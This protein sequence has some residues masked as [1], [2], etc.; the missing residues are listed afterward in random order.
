[1]AAKPDLRNQKMSGSSLRRPLGR[2]RFMRENYRMGP[3]LFEA[4]VG[5]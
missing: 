5:Q 2:Q 3:R 4:V 1:M